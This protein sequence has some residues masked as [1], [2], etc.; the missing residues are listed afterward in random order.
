M[1]LAILAYAAVAWGIL[2]ALDLF[3]PIWPVHLVTGFAAIVVGVLAILAVIAAG[4]RRLK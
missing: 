1:R 2:A 4:V 3:W